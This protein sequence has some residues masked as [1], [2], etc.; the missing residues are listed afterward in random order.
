MHRACFAASCDRPAGSDVAHVITSRRSHVLP[1]AG[2][3]RKLGRCIG[4]ASH[5]SLPDRSLRARPDFG[6]WRRLFDDACFNLEEDTHVVL[7][8]NAD[9][10]TDERTLLSIVVSDAEDRGTISAHCA[11][12]AGWRHSSHLRALSLSSRGPIQATTL[13]IR[14]DTHA[15]RTMRIVAPDQA[16]L[17][18]QSEVWSA[19]LH[20]PGTDTT[21]PIEID[22]LLAEATVSDRVIWTFGDSENI[23][24]VHLESARQCLQEFWRRCDAWHN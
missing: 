20:P 19:D 12:P 24:D 18:Q 17:V 6:R 2:S 23:S 3:P 15:A 21:A 7:L 8:D 10:F 14:F 4:T 11:N 5:R 13:T 16:A 1:F 9:P 22:A